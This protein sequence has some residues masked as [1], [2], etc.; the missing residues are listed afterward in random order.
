[1]GGRRIF[2]NG[3]LAIL[4]TLLV[5]AN[6]LGS[7][8]LANAQSPASPPSPRASG[9][10]SNAAPQ[11]SVPSI[12][13]LLVDIEWQGQGVKLLFSRAGRVV[14]SDGPR[15]EQGTFRFVEPNHVDISMGGT[16]H[17]VRIQHISAQTLRTQ[18]LQQASTGPLR[19]YKAA[20]SRTASAQWA[21]VEYDN[22][23]LRP[24][25]DSNSASNSGSAA[26]GALLGVILLD[27][28][29]RGLASDDPGPPS[30]YE[31]LEARERQQQLDRLMYE[32]Q[33]NLDRCGNI[34][35]C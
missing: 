6:P 23:Q 33:R 15:T 8:R 16:R 9:T 29:L 17:Y 3:F 32:R 20:S 19:E 4:L 13:D 12:L 35:G 18:L 14:R 30:S 21:A 25:P 11:P 27:T 5:V 26:V 28:M 31:N 34:N 22:G 7:W 24:I 10:A 1:M 2:R